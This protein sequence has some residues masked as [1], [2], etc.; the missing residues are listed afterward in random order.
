MGK[1]KKQK[2]DIFIALRNF[3]ALNL[4]FQEKYFTKSES[5]SFPR[6]LASLGPMASLML[7]TQPPLRVQVQA[8]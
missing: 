7:P 1:V 3:W 8:G 2:P 6:V 4:G 5:T